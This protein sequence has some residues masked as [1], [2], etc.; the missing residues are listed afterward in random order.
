MEVCKP[1]SI[2]HP[3]YGLLLQ[4]IISCVQVSFN[5][6]V[7]F[8]I[9]LTCVELG[10]LLFFKHCMGAQRYMAIFKERSSFGAQCGGKFLT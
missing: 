2:E 4:F 1:P 6:L 5:N 8:D 9:S 7:L 3:S 10:K